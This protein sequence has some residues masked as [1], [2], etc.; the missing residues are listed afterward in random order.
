MAKLEN[1]SSYEIYEDGRI[2]SYKSRKWLTLK[3]R[4]D[5]YIRVRLVNDNGEA[6]GLY[7]HRI[8]AQTFIPNPEN[9]P[10]VNHKDENRMNCHKDNLEWR[11]Y[12][13]KNN[14]GIST[15]I[16]VQNR[17]YETTSSAIQVAKMHKQTGKILEIFPSIKEAGR[18]CG[19]ASH[20]N[21]AAHGK[22]KSACGFYWKIIEK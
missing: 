17:I 21:E 9:L 1:Y 15:E 13:Y 10:C 18:K 2:Y 3:P 5:G 6:K 12:E 22:R 19:S 7:L 14:Y 4:Q 11:T 16:T 8:I 20:I